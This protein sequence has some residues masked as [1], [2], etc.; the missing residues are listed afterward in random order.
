MV[1]DVSHS[2]TF[3]WPFRSTLNDTPENDSTS[4]STTSTTDESVSVCQCVWQITRRQV[5]VLLCSGRPDRV[6]DET[7]DREK[8]KWM[9]VEKCAGSS[10]IGMLR[11]QKKR[12]RDK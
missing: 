8:K 9:R 6:I 3:R 11:E 1:R 4:S 7:K 2:V 10:G 5:C 12:K